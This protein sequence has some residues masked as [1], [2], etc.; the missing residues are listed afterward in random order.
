MCMG[1]G[2]RECAHSFV[3]MCTCVLCVYVCVSVI[4]HIWEQMLDFPTSCK[5][6]ARCKCIGREVFMDGFIFIYLNVVLHLY[7]YVC[8]YRDGIHIYVPVQYICLSQ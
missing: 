1:L 3:C 4:A 8:V 6:T 5:C 2:G 7:T